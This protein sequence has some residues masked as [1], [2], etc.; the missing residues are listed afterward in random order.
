M[1]LLLETS[2]MIDALDISGLAVWSPETSRLI[3]IEGQR[4]WM[5]ALICG[6]FS[7][8]IRILKVLAY[9]PVPATGQGYGVQEKKTVSSNATEMSKEETSEWDL[10]QE[11][12]RLRHIVKDRKQGREAWRKEIR[13][14]V[15]QLGRGVAANAIDIALPGTVVGWLKLDSFTVGVAMF[16]TSI[17]TSIPVW[18]RC[19]REEIR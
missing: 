13:G 11:Q 18:E 1:Y 9:T 16:V 19:G 15:Y 8:L 7:G 10:K 5:F 12:Q 6:V 4:F 14:K 17:L 3:N 2:T